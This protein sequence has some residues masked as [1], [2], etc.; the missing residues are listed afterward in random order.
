MKKLFTLLLVLFGTQ[1]VKS[2]IT[3]FNYLD[4]TCE[5]RVYA[6]GFNGVVVE[7]QY[8]TIYFDGDTIINGNAYYKRYVK[9]NSTITGTKTNAYD[10]MR[11]DNSGKFWIYS[12]TNNTE[13]MELDNQILANSQVGDPYPYPDP[14]NTVTNPCYVGQIGVSNL[15]TIQLKHIY[16]SNTQA[17]TGC[18]EGIGFVG[19]ACGASYDW[20][21]NLCYYSKQNDTIQFYN[22]N[23]SSFPV[24]LRTSF[25]AVVKNIENNSIFNIYPN[26]VSD[27]VHFQSE[28][29]IDKK[30]FV[31]KITDVL[32]RE[33]L[34]SEYKEQLDVSYLE[35][36]I[37]FIKIEQGAKTLGVKKI[38]KQ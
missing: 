34:V 31:I 3:Y 12:S 16:G 29:I 9:I 13:S 38:I 19:V 4:Y 37:Y 23:Y 17:Y 7:Y 5:W 2:Q 15:N 20:G 21:E 28:T 6:G 33:V 24:P 32:G 35:K 18:M 1:F 11:E 27:A 25:V 30:N 22:R 36:G 8:K 14:T 10:F 26:P